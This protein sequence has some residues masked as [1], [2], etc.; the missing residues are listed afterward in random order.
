MSHFPT[1]QFTD[2]P[3]SRPHPAGSAGARARQAV[4]RAMAHALPG[5]AAAPTALSSL[6]PS[7]MQDLLR[8]DLDGSPQRELLEVLAACLRHTQALAITVSIAQQTLTLTV[9]PLDRLVHCPIP[10]AEFLA[11][12]LTALQVRQVQPA[13]LRPPGSAEV[14]RVGNPAM[15]APLGPLLWGVA[16][17]GG[18]DTLLPELAGQAAYRVSPGISLGGLDVPGAMANCITRLRRQTCNLREIAGWPGVG[19]ERA[20][21]LLNALYL[22]SGLIVS[23]THPAATN[24]GWSGYGS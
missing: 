14:A 20:M 9:F 7:L 3:D 5:R 2:A 18:R 4:A 17:K 23:R 10:M 11:Y 16:L 22:Q 12:D 24:D 13:S 15:Y 1:T 21:R 6:S 19:P 8:F